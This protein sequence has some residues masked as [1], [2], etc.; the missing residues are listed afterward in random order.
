MA[1]YYTV[2]KIETR[3]VERNGGGWNEVREKER[4]KEKEVERERSRGR[5]GK[6]E[7]ER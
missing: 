7:G 4:E 2:W 1:R 5:E 6:R 3:G